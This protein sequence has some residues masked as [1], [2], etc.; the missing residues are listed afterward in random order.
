MEDDIDDLDDI[1]DPELLL[2]RELEKRASGRHG[3]DR[4]KGGERS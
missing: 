2:E 3:T 4:K 1:D